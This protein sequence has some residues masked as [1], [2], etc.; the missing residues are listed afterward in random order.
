[1]RIVRCGPSAAHVEPIATSHF[2][3]TNVSPLL[4]L[5]FTPNSQ[6]DAYYDRYRCLKDNTAATALLLP[7]IT[8]LH[9]Q[10]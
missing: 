7:L 1:M 10:S 2:M 9:K 6:W 4:P 8:Q 5:S 3:A